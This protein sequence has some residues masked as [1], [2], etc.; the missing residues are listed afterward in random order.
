MSNQKGDGQNYRSWVEVDLDNFTHNWNEMRRLVGPD[1]K[2]LSVVKADAY[3]HGAIEISNVALKNGAYYLGVANADEGVQLRVGGIDAPVLILSPS[4]GL[5]IDEIIKY[6]LTPSVS[7]LGFAR[8]LQKKLKKAQVKM[9]IHIEVDTGMGRGGTIHSEA[10]R[11]IEEILGFPNLAIEGIFTHLSS[12]EVEGDD[13]NEKQWR[14]FQALLKKLDDSRIYIPVKHLANSGGLL[15]FNPFHLDMVRPGIMSYGIYPSESLK[16]KA[17]LLPVMSFKTKVLLLKEFPKGY[18]IGY[19]RTYITK[20]PTRIATIPV[21]YGDGYGV[22][23]SNQGEALIRGRRVPLVGRVSMDMCT[24]DVSRLPECEVGDEVVLLGRQGGEYIPANDIAAKAKTISYEVLCALGKRAPRVFIEKGR[25][26][27][28]EPRLRRVFIPDEVKSISRIDNVI[29]R[30]FQT[31]ARSSELGDAI[32]YEMFEAL[33]GKEDRQ[34]ELRTNF[35]YD[36][37][38]SDFTPDERAKDA[39]AGNFFKVSTHIEYSKTLRNS[40]FL[41]GCALNNRQLSL[42]FDDPRCEYRWLLT[43]SDEAFRESDFRVVRVCVDNEAVPIIRS[44][45]TERGYE[46][47]CGGGDSLRKKLNRQ[48]RMKIEIE[49]KKF[50]SNNLFSVFLVYPTRGLDIDFNYEGMNLKNVR[51]ISFFAGKHPYPEVTKE[52]GKRIRI[53]ISDDEWI[54]P[55][56]GVTFLWDL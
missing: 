17:D 10:F 56:S 7:D 36:I 46:I 14:L 52:T 47:W 24:L 50:R 13:C 31:R 4:M 45:T 2:I 40:I 49:T 12:S 6:N 1:V 34:L 18:G 5:E 11:T 54:F 38:V 16:A 8:E 27:S 15:N 21:G 32:Y 39:Q 23:L 42:L 19:N 48:V 43:T 20:K 28:V 29:R 51:E 37:K 35:R 53:R 3:G 22:I 55:N 26:G 30:C 33:F 41:I 44:E 25:A 9:P